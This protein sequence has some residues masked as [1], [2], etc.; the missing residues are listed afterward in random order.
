MVGYELIGNTI[1]ETLRWS[2]ATLWKNGVAQRLSNGEFEASAE[3]VFSCQAKMYTSLDAKKEL[4]HCEK[5]AL[6]KISQ[7][8]VKLRGLIPFL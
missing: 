5:M 3:S 2:V 6:L 4:L 1:C 7:M 8:E